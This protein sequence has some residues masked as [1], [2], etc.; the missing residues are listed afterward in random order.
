MS[1][2]KKLEMVGSSSWCYPEMGEECHLAVQEDHR[3]LDKPPARPSCTSKDRH[4][5]GQDLCQ[6]GNRGM[7]GPQ[8]IASKAILCCGVV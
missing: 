5:I 8:P 6:Q 1:K 4:E 7:K 2:L 3:F